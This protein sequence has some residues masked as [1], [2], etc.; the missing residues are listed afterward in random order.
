MTYEVVG[1]HFEKQG[2]QPFLANYANQRN[3]EA[4]RRHLKRK[5]KWGKKVKANNNLNIIICS[6]RLKSHL[7]E[8]T[9]G[10]DCIFKLKL[11]VI[12][13]NYDRL[14]ESSLA[15]PKHYTEFKTIEAIK[16]CEVALNK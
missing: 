13:L 5:G 11:S 9:K 4:K 3:Y 2:Y 15:A 16:N 12:V 8:A 10:P 14:T 7:F 6:S 1:F